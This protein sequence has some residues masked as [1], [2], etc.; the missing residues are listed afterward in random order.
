MLLSPKRATSALTLVL[1]FTSLI[2]GPVFSKQNSTTI[3]GWGLG[4]KNHI[5][6]GPP[7]NS[8]HVGPPGQSVNAVNITQ[9]NNSN[10]VNNLN[11]VSNNG[12]NSIEGNSGGVNI[13]SSAANV[14][15]NISNFVGNNLIR[16]V[17]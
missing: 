1:V 5:H 16:F 7:G 6:I 4:D 14:V 2:A 17:R 3:A 8:I 15:T 13:I 10:I 12:N 11:I 9:S